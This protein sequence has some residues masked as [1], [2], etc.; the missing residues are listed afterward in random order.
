MVKEGYELPDNMFLGQ[1][2]TTFSGKNRIV[3]PKKFRQEVADGVI[4]LIEGFDGGIWGF[5]T[6]DWEREA[7]KRLEQDLTSTSG[8]RDR[9][10]FFSSA[11][12]CSLDGQGRFIIPEAMVERAHLKEHILIVGAG[13]HFEIWEDS[14]YQKVLENHADSI[15]IK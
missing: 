8:R 5:K 2:I 15:L 13:D 1:F 4:Y 12:I 9:R 6:Q 11:D 10:K 14:D 3:L 7:G